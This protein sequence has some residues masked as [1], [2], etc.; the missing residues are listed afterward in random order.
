[1]TN[2]SLPVSVCRK[3][4]GGVRILHSQ[5][6]FVLIRSCLGS[7]VSTCTIMHVMK[8]FIEGTQCAGDIDIYQGLEAQCII[9]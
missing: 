9:Q 7:F 3:Y 2:D 4:V 8:T 6:L 5:L 1:M